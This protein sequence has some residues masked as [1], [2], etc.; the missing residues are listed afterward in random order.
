MGNAT[1]KDEIWKAWESADRQVIVAT[2][3]FRL[4]INRLDIHVI[5]YIRP[6]Y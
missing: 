1:I 6:I 5:V 3:A 2:N 4:G